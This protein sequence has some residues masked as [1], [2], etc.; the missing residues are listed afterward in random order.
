MAAVCP[1]PV[2]LIGLIVRWLPQVVNVMPEV[3]MEHP[4]IRPDAGLHGQHQVVEPVQPRG[5]KRVEV[6]MVVVDGGH[7]HAEHGQRNDA[8]RADQGRRHGPENQVEDQDPQHV[9]DGAPV[10]LVLEEDSPKFV[11]KIPGFF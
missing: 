1:G 4:G 5:A 11:P 8:D 2:G 6:L 9:G 10:G 3:V 7:K